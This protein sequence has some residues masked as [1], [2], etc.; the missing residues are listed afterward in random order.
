MAAHP[1]CRA[2]YARDAL[3]HPPRD[4][5]TVMAA[6]S[7]L[8][9]PRGDSDR[10][11]RRHVVERPLNPAHAPEAL[12]A[13]THR[14]HVA[15]ADEQV[16]LADLE[17]LAPVLELDHFGRVQHGEQRIAVFLDLRS[18]M[19]FARI[20][21]GKLVQAELLRHLVE[22]LSRRLEQR[23]PDEVIRPMHVFADV[24]DG[25]IGDLATFFV[26]D[27]AHEHYWRLPESPPS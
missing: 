14:Q 12:R 8:R 24:L 23:D 1:R 18:L 21:D 26:G 15:R 7:R 3:S 10:A 4:A 19:P 9:G 16:D 2:P 6:P 25:N 27:A 22:L 11:G 5:A 13:M 17:L 20:L